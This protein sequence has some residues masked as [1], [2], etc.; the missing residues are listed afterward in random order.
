[1]STHTDPDPR[2]IV[3]LN[4]GRL[5]GLTYVFVAQGRT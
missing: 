3:E 5:V 2:D 1:M 4:G